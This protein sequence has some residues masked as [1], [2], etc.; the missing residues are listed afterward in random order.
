VFEF[1]KGVVKTI[2]FCLARWIKPIWG[3][4]GHHHVL[5]KWSWTQSWLLKSCLLFISWR[6][7][8]RCFIRLLKWFWELNFLDCLPNWFL[9]IPSSNKE[10]LR[11]S[12][13][14]S[15]RGLKIPIKHIL[16]IVHIKVVSIKLGSPLQTFF[17]SCIFKF[18][19][20]LKVSSSSFLCFV[21]VSESKDRFIESF[22]QKLT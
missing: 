22:L 5:V 9:N 14:L 6:R 2:A 4:F 8:N 19:F 20:Q 10:V 1:Q 3:C 16:A 11:R 15:R 13:I 21:S 12:I 17:E 7:S 18:W